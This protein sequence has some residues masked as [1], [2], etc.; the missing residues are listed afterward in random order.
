MRRIDTRL[1]HGSGNARC[2]T[3]DLGPHQAAGQVNS[4]HT[5]MPMIAGIYVRICIRISTFS[6]VGVE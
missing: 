6:Y 3:N 4:R 5:V 1:Q 2:R